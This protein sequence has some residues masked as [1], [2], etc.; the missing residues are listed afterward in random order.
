MTFPGMG[1]KGPARFHFSFTKEQ[2]YDLLMRAA[3][4]VIVA[5]FLFWFIMTFVLGWNGWV[6]SANIT[7]GFISPR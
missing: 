4:G 5:G 2:Q 3:I 7:G 1:R 6:D